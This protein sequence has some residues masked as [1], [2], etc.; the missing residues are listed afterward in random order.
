LASRRRVRVT[1]NPAPRI[2]AG[3]ERGGARRQ[4]INPGQVTEDQ[5]SAIA[6][7]AKVWAT[8][9]KE[10]TTRGYPSGV[11]PGRLGTSLPN[12]ENIPDNRYFGDP[13]IE[14]SEANLFAQSDNAQGDFIPL[15]YAPTKTAF[16]GN[17]WDH[18]RTIAAGYSASQGV[19]RVQFYTDG[20]IY[21]Y[22]TEHKVPPSVAK[23]FRMAQSPGRFIN[24]TLENY[25]YLRV[26]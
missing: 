3:V 24:T 21:D 12:S 17:G 2:A 7:R 22:G 4:A 19:L 13:Y 5:Q 8:G 23:S 20:A 9:N 26:N 15:T 16:P 6:G 18:R 11:I 1:S 14:N 25:G 10:G